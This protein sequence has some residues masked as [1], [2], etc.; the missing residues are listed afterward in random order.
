M[1][2]TGLEEFKK[3]LHAIPETLTEE[4]TAIAKLAASEAYAEARSGYPEQSRTERGTGHLAAGLAIRERETTSKYG[5]AVQLVNRAPHALIY[6][7]GTAARYT[8]RRFRASRG[9]MPPGRVFVPAAVR[10]RS[11]MYERLIALIVSKG[12]TVTGAA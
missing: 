8:H 5:V 11:R 4:A 7:N 12:F 10:A 1:K 3:E 9:S 6:E 2:W